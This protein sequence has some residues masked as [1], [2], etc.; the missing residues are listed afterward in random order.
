MTA[1]T[2]KLTGLETLLKP[3]SV[4]VIGAS[5]VAT[6][7][8]GAPIHNLKRFG[9]RGD[10]Y[11]VNPNRSEVQGVPCFPSVLDIPKPVD[12][13]LVAVPARYAIQV[14]E[15]CVEKGVPS[16][17]LVTAGFAEEAAGDEGQQ[18][19]AQLDALIRTSGIRLLGPNT[20]GMVNLFDDYVP[21]AANNHLEPDRLRLGSVALIS[22]SGACGNTLFNRAQANGVGVSLSVATGDQADV[23]V[24]DLSEY[25]LADPRISVLMLIVE[26]FGDVAKAS[27]VSSAALAANKPIVLLKLGQSRIG[28]AVVRAHSGAVAGNS[29]VQAAVLRD[30]G[31]ISVRD[32]DELWEVARLVESWG[33][34]SSEPIRLGVVSVSGG[35]AAMIADQCEANGIALPPASDTFAAFVKEHFE[36]AKGAN[37]FDPTGEVVSRPQKLREGLGA[38]VTQNDYSHLLFASPV[39]GRDLAERYYAELPRALENLGVGVAFSLWPAGEF[40]A[41]QLE[42]LSG[43]GSPVIPN[44][45]RAVRALARYQD[46]G[47]RRPELL[48]DSELRHPAAEDAATGAGYE[49]L[50]YSQARETLAT[51]GLPFV[52]ARVCTSPDEAADAVG[53]LG[54]R[55]VLKANV[56]SS[57]H[58]ADHG[59][60]EFH[61]D[62]DPDSVR[63]AYERIVQA[64]EQWTVSSVVVEDF[65]HGQSQLI[66]G[67]HRDAEFGPVVLFGSGGG[68][69]EFLDDVALALAETVTP[70]AGR[71]L[72]GRTKIG[73]YL[74]AKAPGIAEELARAVNSLAEFITSH[75]DC[76]DI[77]INPC[78]VD[79]VSKTW[80]C[81]DARI[82]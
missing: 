27:T 70:D 3:R 4:A 65:A 41:A 46:Y 39:F 35:E 24:W 69:V 50:T 72:V 51:L 63:A 11:A 32:L 81:A 30:F 49:R 10:L 62:A 9:Y 67:A 60:L 21:R 45:A 31:I 29:E 54:G 1:Q 53:A 28:G 78:I 66:L 75:P 6:T 44:S 61:V 34:P 55:V 17:T 76:H 36:Y 13:A 12:T 5:E 47:L 73:T 74:Q 22:Q 20:A 14:L 18:R 68:P 23:D 16:A 58:K 48:A 77:D 64:G 40:T 7:F 19:A 43:S 82:V 80:A 57:V 56:P 52:A 8:N 37:P 59:L 71:R 25:C 33:A 2:D 15:E 79:T 26:S 42:L 38:F